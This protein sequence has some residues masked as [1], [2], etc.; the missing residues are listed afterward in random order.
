MHGLT[1]Q[2]SVYKAKLREWL[3]LSGCNAVF[4]ELDDEEAFP[5]ADFRPSWTLDDM[6]QF[7]SQHLTN[8]FCGTEKVGRS[9]FAL[10]ILAG[11][12]Q[13]G[14]DAFK[15]HL[16]DSKRQPLPWKPLVKAMSRKR[17]M[18]P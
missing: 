18:R 11:E 4:C 14:I 5:T 1:F 2:V 6:R 17:A 15:P 7:G 16:K 3:C 8:M 13:L 9:Q 12:Y 10:R